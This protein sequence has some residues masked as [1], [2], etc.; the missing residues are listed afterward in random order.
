MVVAMT[1]RVARATPVLFF[2]NRNSTLGQ[3]YLLVEGVALSSF[4]WLV[5]SLFLHGCLALLNDQVLLFALLEVLSCSLQSHYSLLRLL[6][7]SP[8]NIATLFYSPS[9]PSLQ[10]CVQRTLL[11][12]SEQQRKASTAR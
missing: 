9:L 4:G 7:N 5:C 8:A 3:M 2:H 11:P 1:R 12:S 6:L 10:P